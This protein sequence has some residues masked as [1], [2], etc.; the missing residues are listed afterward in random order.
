MR[1]VP[2][3]YVGSSLHAVQAARPREIVKEGFSARPALTAECAS[4]R[5]PSCGGRRP[6]EICYRIV[7]VGLDRPSKLRSR[8]LVTAEAI[9]RYARVSHPD[10]SHRIARTEAQGLTNVSLGFFGPT[11]K[12]LAISDIRMGVGEFRSS[13]NACSHSAMPCAARLV[14]MSTTPNHIWPRASFGTDDRALVNSASA[15][16]KAATGSVT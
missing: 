13:S 12:D 5:R 14:N 9:F 15:A 11:D 2:A 4:S 6:I 10:V 1:S 7:S 16:V 3:R 8:L